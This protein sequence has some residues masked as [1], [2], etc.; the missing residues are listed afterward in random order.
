MSAVAVINRIAPPANRAQMISSF[1]S[2]AYLGGI[3][4]ILGLGLLA[5]SVNTCASP[6]CS[7]ASVHLESTNFSLIT[8]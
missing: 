7:R 8:Q 2:I 3:V 4:P 6:L 1:F 5:D